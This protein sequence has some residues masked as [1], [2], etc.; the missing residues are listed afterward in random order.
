MYPWYVGVVVAAQSAPEEG[1]AWEE[2]DDGDRLTGISALVSCREKE[3]VRTKARR[4]KDD[5]AS[6]VREMEI[7]APEAAL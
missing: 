2:R 3:M 7:I 4:Q 1:T 5:H 6:Y